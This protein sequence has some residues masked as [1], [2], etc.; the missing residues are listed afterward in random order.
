MKTGIIIQ[1]RIGSTRLPGKVLKPIH[2]GNKPTVIE[3]IVI[4]AKAVTNADVVILATSVEHSDDSLVDYLN[5]TLDVEIYRG[6]ES[7]VLSRYYEAA[8]KYDLDQIVRL[9]GDNP[10]IDYINIETI[11]DD[12]IAKNAD[13]SYS[14]G[15]PLGMNV[16]IVKTSALKRAVKEGITEPDKEHVTFYVRNNPEKFHLNFFSFQEINEIS[17]LRLTMDTE[18]DYILL[19]ILYDNLYEQN[20]LFG[21]KEIKHLWNTKPYVFD[22]NKNV[23]QKNIFKNEE[24][25]LPTAITFLKKQDLFFSAK[26]LKDKIEGKN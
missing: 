8:L 17:S 10:C 11:I 22:I 24:E 20:N 12:H 16:E 25:E 6:S 26:I 1:A 3:Q 19:R 14:S 13:Y 18:E 4:R 5:N 2:G 23:T 21:I 7:N 15:L 9:T